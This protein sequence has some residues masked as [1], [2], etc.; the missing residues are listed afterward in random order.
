MGKPC[1]KQGRGWGSEAL[2]SKKRDAPYR[3]GPS[4]AWITIKTSAW[5]DARQDR[6]KSFE[7]RGERTALRTDVTALKAERKTQSKLL[8]KV[9]AS[10]IEI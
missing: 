2:F 6:G 5:R 1:S 4:H 7:A 3:S 8:G 9:S 10:V